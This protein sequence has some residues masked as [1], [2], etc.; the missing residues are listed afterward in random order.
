[1]CFTFSINKSATILGQLA[2]EAGQLVADMFTTAAA[3]IQREVN[4][5]IQ[6]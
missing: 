1:M 3:A 2:G 6:H 5:I 4:R